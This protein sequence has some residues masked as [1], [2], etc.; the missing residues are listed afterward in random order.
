MFIFLLPERQEK[1]REKQAVRSSTP[2]WFLKDQKEQRL[3]QPKARRSL[4]LHRATVWMTRAQGRQP[5][6]AAFQV[7]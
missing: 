6:A 1:G 4:E 7:C 5:P 3:C 2:D